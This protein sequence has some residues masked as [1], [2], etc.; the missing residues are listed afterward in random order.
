MSNEKPSVSDRAMKFFIC[1]GLGVV[2]LVVYSPC[3]DYPFCNQDDYDYVAENSHVRPGLSVANLRW[4][5]TAFECGNWH[6]LTW[7]SLQLDSTF[8][9]GERAGG[10]H[11]TNVLFHAANAVLLFL[12][13]SAMTEAIWR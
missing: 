5:F 6:P 1:V 12:V 4:A 3:F 11:V 8:Y 2:T 10:F 13:L 9:G 7:L